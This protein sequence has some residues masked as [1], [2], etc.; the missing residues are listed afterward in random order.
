MSPRQLGAPNPGTPAWRAMHR[1]RM[2]AFR[3]AKRLTHPP[4]CR[5]CSEICEFDPI[6]MR[7]R[8]SCP[9]HLKADRD[10]A[11]AAYKKKKKAKRA[12]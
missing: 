5:Q 7:Y 8:T 10:R 4:T 9:K 1:A 11:D 6:E 2:A 12:A 3:A